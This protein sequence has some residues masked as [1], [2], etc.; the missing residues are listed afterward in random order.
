MS[1]YYTVIGEDGHPVEYWAGQVDRS[2]FTDLSQEEQQICLAWIKREFEPAKRVMRDSSSYGLK[3][4]IQNDPSTGHIYM[5]NNQFKDLMLS[6]GYEPDNPNALNWYFKI[7]F[8][9]KHTMKKF[10]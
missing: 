2:R 8:V 1:K 3:H 10:M 7:K 4:L 6:V 9:R 5:S